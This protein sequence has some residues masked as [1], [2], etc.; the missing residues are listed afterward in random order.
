MSDTHELERRERRDVQR[1]LA[2]VLQAAQ[3]LFAERGA[4]VKMEEVARRAGVGVG[5]VYRRFPSKEHLFAAVSEAAC[6]DTRRCLAEAVADTGDPIEQLR[7]IIV[8]QYQRSLHQAALL[9]LRPA[10]ATR[11]LDAEHGGLYAALHELLARVIMAGQR[12]GRVRPGNPVMLAAI[13]LE[14]LSPR[15]VRNLCQQAGDCADQAADQ[16]ATFVV[17]GLAQ[18]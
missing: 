8:V 14:L 12:Q 10:D 5:T 18:S 9:E 16:V 13:T 15:S 17:A 7:A 2:R 11:P 6:H 4:E 1:N 3:E